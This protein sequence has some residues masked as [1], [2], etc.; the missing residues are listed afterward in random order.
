MCIKI[1]F[2]IY[3]D[4]EDG[5]QTQINSNKK[6]TTQSAAF[7]KI[8]FDLFVLTATEI[9]CVSSCLLFLGENLTLARVT[10]HALLSDDVSSHRIWIAVVSG[11]FY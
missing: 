5:L 1:F 6:F 11:A 10:S 3:H 8:L 9:F 4:A 7:K 2:C